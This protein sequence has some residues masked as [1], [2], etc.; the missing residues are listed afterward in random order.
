L[1]S[2]EVSAEIGF[3][4]VSMNV[5]MLPKPIKW[6]YQHERSV[7]LSEQLIKLD[8]DV[9]FFQE[10]FQENFR[11]I[12][13]EKMKDLYPHF[14]YLDKPS[15]FSNLF[16]SG[17]FVL[18]RKPMKVLE[19]IYFDECE[20]F[21]CFASKGVVLLQIELTHTKSIQLAVTHL[22]AGQNSAGIRTKQL[23]QISQLLSKHKKDNTV[24]FIAGD[25]NI[26]FSDT[27]FE[28]AL[29][30]TKMAYAPLNGDIKTTN[31]RSNDCYDT[32]TRKLWIDH[33]W[34][35][36]VSNIENWQVNVTDLNFELNQK[37]CPLSDH[38][39]IE[40]N[41]IFK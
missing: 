30:L 10:A 21:D 39:A 23:T 24:Q 25:I 31:A 38:H 7:A 17:I 29:K 11:T 3:K 2:F 34:T 22:Q 8:Y 15:L 4:L 33:I 19:A 41:L 27:E 9:I 35:S 40:A 14:Y 5:Y 26:D 18:S 13:I 12:T 20:S 28:Q 6:T 1:L 36:D 37:V 16:G 32:P